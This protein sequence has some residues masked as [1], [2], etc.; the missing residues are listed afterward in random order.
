MSEPAYMLA[1][2]EVFPKMQPLEI[3]LMCA[4]DANLRKQVGHSEHHHR[5]EAM[6]LLRPDRTWHNFRD[7]AVEGYSRARASGKKELII[8]GSA[9]SNKTGSLADI[10]LEIWWENPKAT[11]IYITSPYETATETGIWAE[12]L[13]SFD[14]SRAIHDFL[15][16]KVKESDNAIV[17]YDRNPRSFIRVVTVDQVGKLVGKKSKDWAS[18]M[19]IVVCDE[20]PDFKRGGQALI[21][22]LKNLRFNPNFMLIGAGNFADPE[23]AL[24]RLSKPAI[25]GGYESLDVDLDQEWVTSRNGLVIRLDGHQSPNVLAGKDY[26][27]FVTRIEAL[28]EL[29]MTEGGKD[30]AGYMRYGRSFPV[31]SA[32]EFTV[33]NAAKIQAGL[34]YVK[35]EFTAG[36]KF[37]GAHL[38]PGYGGDPCVLQPFAFG[39]GYIENDVSHILEL[40]EGPIVIPIRVRPGM[41]GENLKIVEQ[42]IAEATLAHLER[43]KIPIEHFSFDGSLRAGI[44]QAM[45]RIIG[46][47]VMAFDYGGPATSRPL[48]VIKTILDPSKPRDQRKSKT[49]KEAYHN[50]NTEL[51][52]AVAS[53]IDSQQ[54]RGMQHSRQG[55]NQLC[56]RRWRW[57]G[58]R[59]E[60]EPKVSNESGAKE[61]NWGY[62]QRNGGRSPNEADA[63]VG[64]MENARRHGFRL[65]GLIGNAGGSLALIQDMQREMAARALVK[66][67]KGESLPLGSLRSME[68]THGI[69][70]PHLHS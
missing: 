20:L 51:H 31:T 22:V 55:V 6:K 4:S 39:E 47:N 7:R 60:I 11:S 32:N 19:I 37:I 24:G 3:E 52:F 36:N 1:L 21:D 66:Q 40:T 65:T 15:P 48:S 26:L 14:A 25:E 33:T 63:I 28:K 45:M 16:G 54:I 2:R 8:H 34:C 59:R 57:A 44:V 30:T 46:M 64:C 41:T 18:G 35:P 56:I 10:A 27:P 12:I 29:E 42:M 67:L 70:R 38:D 23:D 50:L 62:K 58:K 53:A 5:S 61:K 69:V 43:L 17:M 9:S 68:E 13:E 49:A